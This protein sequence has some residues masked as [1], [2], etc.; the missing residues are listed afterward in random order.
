[1]AILSFI[2]DQKSFFC[3]GT[4]LLL[5]VCQL[6]H[7]G[8]SEKRPPFAHVSGVSGSLQSSRSLHDVLAA[9]MSTVRVGMQSAD[10]ITAVEGSRSLG[11][12]VRAQSPGQTMRLGRRP[13]GDEHSLSEDSIEDGDDETAPFLGSRHSAD[14]PLSEAFN[15][16]HAVGITRE[17]SSFFH[18]VCDGRAPHPP[19]DDPD[20]HVFDHVWRT[21]GSALSVSASAPVSGMHTRHDLKPDGTPWAT[22]TTSTTTT[23]SAALSASSVSSACGR[24][25]NVSVH[26]SSG[27]CTSTT[28]ADVLEGTVMNRFCRKKVCASKARARERELFKKSLYKEFLSWYHEKFPTDQVVG[29]LKSKDFFDVYNVSNN[30]LQLRV[31]RRIARIIYINNCLKEPSEKPT[32]TSN[33]KY[34][35]HDSEAKRLVAYMQMNLD[36]TSVNALFTDIDS[37]WK[38][39]TQLVKKRLIYELMCAGSYK[40][41]S[42][43]LERSKN[44]TFKKPNTFIE[45]V[46]DSQIF[47][48]FSER[49]PQ[50]KKTT[51]KD[52][53]CVL[54][55]ILKMLSVAQTAAVLDCCLADLEKYVVSGEYRTG[56]KLQLGLLN[57]IMHVDHENIMGKSFNMLDLYANQILK[58]I[59]HFFYDHSCTV[60]DIPFKLNDFDKVYIPFFDKIEHAEPDI[61]R[62]KGTQVSDDKKQQFGYKNPKLRA[63]VLK[64]INLFRLI[65]LNTEK[66]DIKKK[67]IEYIAAMIIRIGRFTDKENKVYHY[68][69]TQDTLDKSMN[70]ISNYCQNMFHQL[71]SHCDNRKCI[72]LVMDYVG[73][74]LQ[75]LPFTISGSGIQEKRALPL[76]QEIQAPKKVESPARCCRIA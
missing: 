68:D 19:L 69:G 57:N 72:D 14:E 5:V 48:R 33:L 28:T 20:T 54:Q 70:I 30:A 60:F 11:V 43:L 55:H 73:K 42:K 27:T 12:L 41:V 16:S 4:F 26:G 66:D 7:A 29:E 3:Y 1:M 62:K 9:R 31:H 64:Y 75:D 25:I 47:S 13:V 61:S 35:L 38:Y 51:P 17:R 58:S 40:E 10:G 56:I 52:T 24:T 53:S 2:T 37:H 36:E 8:D 21:G 34:C 49:D 50:I 74:D 46:I 71:L 65:L 6:L 22:T 59:R 39:T 23:T 67:C 15:R 44:I 63:L 45:K 76:P 18:D 32:D